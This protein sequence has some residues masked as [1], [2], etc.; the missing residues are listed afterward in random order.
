[1]PPKSKRTGIW[2][3]EVAGAAIAV[4]FLD[5]ERESRRIDAAI[6]NKE[7]LM[8]CGPA[9][10]GKTTLVLNILRLFPARIASQCLYLPAF[11]D[12]Q[13]LLRKLIR[14]LYKQKDLNLRQ[15]LH[16]ER[17]TVLNFEAW[18]SSLP[19]SRL[20][21]TLYR[22]VEHGE[23]RVLLDHP[24]PLT[25][26][27][28]KIIKEL[29]WMRNTPVYLLLRDSEGFRVD[30]LAHFFY[31]GPRE[32]LTLGPLPMEAAA[33]LLEGCIERFGLSKF[34]LDEFREEVKELSMGVPGAIVKMCALAA[35]PLYQYG[36]RIKT[37]LVHI[38]YLMAAGNFSYW[39]DKRSGF[40]R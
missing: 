39:G 35:D 31:W 34:E 40:T 6:R 10:V 16:A 18:L 21:G 22:T 19:T 11:K 2:S 33:E 26:A 9:G 12:L 25:H 28:A 20:K 1:M 17:V 8:I 29:F 7:S 3:G 4:P 32:R 13:D 15:Q 38:D 36:T 5:R 27:I 23:Y 37:K 30:R 14:A 24:P